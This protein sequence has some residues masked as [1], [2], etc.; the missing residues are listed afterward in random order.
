MGM[1]FKAYVFGKLCLT[2]CRQAQGAP[3]VDSCTTRD[4]QGRTY[5]GWAILLKPWLR[6]EHGA[7]LIQPALILAWRK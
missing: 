5:R 2:W 1:K 6:D 7:S 3:F 4:L